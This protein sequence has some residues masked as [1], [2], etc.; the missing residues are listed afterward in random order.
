MP[1]VAFGVIA[2]VLVLVLIAAAVVDEAGR[3]NDLTLRHGGVGRAASVRR[4]REAVVI[5]VVTLVVGVVVVA[6]V[7]R[8][9]R[10]AADAG[11]SCRV[12]EEREEVVGLMEAITEA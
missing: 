12:A 4:G 2:P 9:K 3:V 8:H 7:K 5:G 1:L 11:G 10:S 6:T